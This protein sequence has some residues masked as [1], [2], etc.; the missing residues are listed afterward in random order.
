MLLKHMCRSMSPDNRI[1]GSFEVYMNMTSYRE[2]IR[3]G[4]M[5]VTSTPG[6][7]TGAVF[8]FSYLLIRG[9]TGQLKEAQSQ[10]E[11]IAITDPLTAEFT[12]GAI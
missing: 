1:L 6:A 8:G 5:L 2:Q 12:T 9:G 3:Q 11:L 4:V 7:G 10:L